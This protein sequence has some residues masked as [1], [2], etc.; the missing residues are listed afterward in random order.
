MDSPPED[1]EEQIASLLHEWWKEHWRNQRTGA[2]LTVN[3][4]LLLNK[5]T[6][7]KSL[8]KASEDYSNLP[9]DEKDKLLAVA[10]KII[11]LFN[12]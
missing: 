4:Y 2:S 9:Q 7:D 12:T 3:G 1:I 11:N 10:S 8:A 6:V 5:R